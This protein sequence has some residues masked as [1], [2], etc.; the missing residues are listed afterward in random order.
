MDSI[1]FRT[2]RPQHE[3]TPSPWLP[4]LRFAAAFFYIN[5]LLSLEIPPASMDIRSLLRV[6][7]DGICLLAGMCLLARP[8]RP[9]KPVVCAAF[10]AAAILIKLFQWADRLVP[11]VFNRALNLFLDSQRLPDL[12][13][14]FWLTRTPETVLMSLLGAGMG[15]A[16]MSWSLW[17]ALQTLHDGLAGEPTRP[18]NIRR[19]AALWSAAM[20]TFTAAAPAGLVGGS[21][22]PRMAE[23]VRFILDLDEIRDR[24]QALLGQA[25][26]RALQTASDLDRLDRAPVFLIVI[27]S[28][29]MSAFSD[30]R[31]AATVLPAVRTAET[32]LRSMGFDMCSM[33]LTA[34]T[35]GGGSWLSHATL[36][37]GVR[38][39]SQIAH[40]LLLASRLVPLAEY[41]NRAGYRTVRAMPATFWPWPEGAYYRYGQMV[42]APDFGYRGPAY[43]FAPMPDQFVL[44]WVARRIIRGASDPLFVEVILTGSHAAF[45]R[46]APYLDDWDRIGDGSVFNT[47]PS[48]RFPFGWSE[49]S[50]ASPA[51]S[52]AIVHVIT[53]LKDFMRRF[54]DGSGLVI[55]VGDH[56]PCVELIGEDQPWSVPVHVISAEPDFIQEFMRRGYT[57]GLVPAQPLPH[58]G[59]DTLFWDLIE[60]FSSGRAATSR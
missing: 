29:G 56:Q 47:L 34:P 59:L 38:I 32:E 36:A 60:G 25:M 57:P 39:D 1:C 14:L 46:Q 49:L 11:A 48:E 51:Y 20:L 52:H 2:D 24:H 50:K 21:V 55:V 40:D 33:Y 58:P 13:F 12:I 53:M 54:I 7:P 9:F 18:W 44:D 45:D 22:F 42:I 23:E 16:V 31:H 30:P 19:I 37:S 4:V 35:F 5:A 26:L 41:F 43:G 10:T 8:G 6:S 28:Y 15:I 17:V 3:A 27:E